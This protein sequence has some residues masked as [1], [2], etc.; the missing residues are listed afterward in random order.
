MEFDTKIAKL[1]ERSAAGRKRVA[2]VGSGISGLSAAWHL[3]DD[4]DVTL[5]EANDY[6]GGH[7][8]TV[9]ITVGDI[10]FPVD[11]GFIVFNPQN[12]PNLT[13]LFELLGVETMKTDMSFS[14]SID[15]GNFE[16][17]GGDGGGLFAQPANL[18]KVRFWSMLT[19]IIKFYR[20]AQRYERDGA[21]N[22]LNLRELLKLE[23]YSKA[24]I[25]DHLAP[26]GAAIW[27]SDSINILDYPAHS[28]LKFF[29]N[30]GLTQ[31]ANRPV[32]RSVINGSCSYVKKIEMELRGKA[33]VYLNCPVSSVVPNG[34]KVDVCWYGQQET[35]DHVI[36]ACH[37][38][39]ARRL[40]QGAEKHRE[41]LKSI[42]YSENKVVLHSDVSLMPKRRKAWASWN[43]IGSSA[44]NAPRPAVSYWMNQ[45]QALPVE[46]PVIVT[47]NPNRPIDPAKIYGEFEYDHPIFD[48]A[49]QAA[50]TKVWAQQGLDNIWLAGAYL[51]DGFHE[52]GIQSGLAVAE[53]I[54]GRRRPWQAADQNKRIGLPDLLP[55]EEPV[56]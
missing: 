56:K 26:M 27:S 3:H 36:L 19:G 29:N 47:L 10:T 16:Y 21:F 54:S 32:W 51:G 5:L 37:S 50:K 12:Y 18:F 52:D 20:N 25:E 30:H 24:F 15:D 22:S 4:H 17:A 41:I 23:G 45:L 6:L 40:L 38:D 7:T 34:D 48:H 31:L 55:L 28:F 9:N 35:F 13:A 33:S 44:S 2:V 11:T 1:N 14:A 53:L 49:A 42:R 46:T 43:Y 39:Q 8:H